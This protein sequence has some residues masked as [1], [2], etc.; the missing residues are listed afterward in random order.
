MPLLKSETKEDETQIR[1]RLKPSLVKE[2]ESYCE[3]AG[4]KDISVFLDQSAAYILKRDKEWLSQKK[5]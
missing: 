2:I 4:L 3:W 5:A 1:I